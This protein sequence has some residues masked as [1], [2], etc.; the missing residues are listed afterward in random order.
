M[1]V[2][3]APYYFSHKLA[4]QLCDAKVTVCPFERTTLYPDWEALQKIITEQQPKMVNVATMILNTA[5]YANYHFIAIFRRVA[6]CHTAAYHV[7]TQRLCSAF[8]QITANAE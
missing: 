6:C 5:N 8:T 4:L 2:I 3:I 1:T 7:L